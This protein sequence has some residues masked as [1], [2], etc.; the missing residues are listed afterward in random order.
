V[1]ANIARVLAFLA[2]FTALTLAWSSDAAATAQTWVIERW[3]VQPAAWLFARLD[4]DRGVEAHGARLTSPDGN[5]HVL[6]GCEGADIAFLLASAMLFA[7]LGW[8][9]RL[10]GGAVG[11][12]LVFTLNQARVIGL[13]LAARHDRELFD[14]LHGSV[15]PLLLVAAVGA[16]FVGWLALAPAAGRSATEPAA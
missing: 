2:V 12:A 4:A 5:V 3:T 1:T 8:R 16:F 11:L 9:L 15:F 14:L 6:P 13:V 7:P 10:L